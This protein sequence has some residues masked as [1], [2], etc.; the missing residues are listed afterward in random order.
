MPIMANA[1]SINGFLIAST[2]IS[3][4]ALYNLTQNTTDNFANF[5]T[6]V[7][8]E[9]WIKYELPEAAVVNFIDIGA[10]RSYS[11]R[12]PTWY[13]IEASNDDEN[14]TTLVERTSKYSVGN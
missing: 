7:D 3:D 2:G 10:P 5:K 13:K 11:D 14:W 6:R 8:G 1:N 12:M 9:F 4:G